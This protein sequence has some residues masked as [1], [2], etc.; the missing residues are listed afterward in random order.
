[1]ESLWHFLWANIN[2]QM[3][4]RRARCLCISFVIRLWRIVHRG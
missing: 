2:L 1:L 3:N 4:L